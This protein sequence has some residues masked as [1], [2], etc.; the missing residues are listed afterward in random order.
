MR[1]ARN[2]NPKMGMQLHDVDRA[3]LGK[4]MHAAYGLITL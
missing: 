1:N 2:H 4:Y 3:I